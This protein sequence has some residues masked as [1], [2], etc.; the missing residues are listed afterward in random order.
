[1]HLPS[2][3]F[4][5]VSDHHS[6]FKFISSGPNGDVIKLIIFTEF[7][8]TRKIYNLALVD[9]I[10]NDKISD[11]NLSNNGDI[12]KI[13]ATVA[14]AIINYTSTFP[15]RT[16]YFE[17]SD[18]QGKRTSVYNAAIRKYFYILEKDFYI[19]G[20]LNEKVKEKFNPL[21]T[22]KGFLVKRK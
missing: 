19:E 13:L 10:E 15:D 18:E 14:Q 17:G 2:Y 16:I 6:V 21:K 20:Y 4:L 7:N 3:Y 22:Y 12:R 5:E 8:P 9:V 11:K 1:M